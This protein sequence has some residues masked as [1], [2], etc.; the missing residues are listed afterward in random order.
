MALEGWTVEEIDYKTAMDIVVKKHYLKRR[1][2]CSKAFGLFSPE[3]ELMGVICYGMP[4][5][6]MPRRGICGNEFQDSVGEL[7]RLWVDDRAPKNGESFLIGRTIRKS[8]YEIIL[9]FAEIQAG[10]RGIVYQATNWIYTGLTSKHVE[11]ILDGDRSKHSRHLFDQYGGVKEARKALGDRIVRSERPRKHRY[12][13]IN[14][15]GARKKEILAAIK[16]PILPYPKED[17]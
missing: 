14:A 4:A 5:S 12:V 11:W 1:A 13:F 10:H 9:S 7:T 15:K 16:Y 6:P 3:H 8:G 2:S 17:A